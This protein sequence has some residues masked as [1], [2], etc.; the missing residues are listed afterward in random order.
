MPLLMCR[1]PP[2]TCHNLKLLLVHATLVILAI[3]SLNIITGAGMVFM[4][5]ILGEQFLL[6]HSFNHNTEYRNMESIL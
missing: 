6:T 2:L 1:S 3:I 5:Y 4:I